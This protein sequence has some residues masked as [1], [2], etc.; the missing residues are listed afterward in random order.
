[1]SAVL[2]EMEI[3]AVQNR[4]YS[5]IGNGSWVPQAPKILEDRLAAMKNMTKV[6]ETLT[7]KS[8]LRPEQLA[9]LDKLADDIVLSLQ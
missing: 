9:E 5:V 2:E 1:M 7:I 6:G 4:K 3:M 8:S